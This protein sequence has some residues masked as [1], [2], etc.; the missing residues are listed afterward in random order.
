MR[1]AFRYIPFIYIYIYIY[2][3]IFIYTYIIYKY[4]QY[5]QKTDT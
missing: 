3:Y 5:I 2:I 4:I 1:K